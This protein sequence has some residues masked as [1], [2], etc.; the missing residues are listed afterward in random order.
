MTLCFRWGVTET[1]LT[2]KSKA[3]FPGLNSCSKGTTIHLTA[4][5]WKPRRL[6]TA[7]ATAL[8]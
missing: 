6:A 2:S 4:F 5:A 7:Y 3:A 8:S 1:W